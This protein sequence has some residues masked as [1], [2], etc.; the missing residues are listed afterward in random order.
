MDHEE[1]PSILQGSQLLPN[2]W[3]YF[4][5]GFD[6]IVLVPKVSQKHLHFSEILKNS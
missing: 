2:F 6:G 3:K 4:G 5:I 1:A